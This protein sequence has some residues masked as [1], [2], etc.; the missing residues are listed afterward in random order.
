MAIVKM[1][2]DLPLV[3]SEQQAVEEFAV[4]PSESAPP[5]RTRVDF[6]STVLRQAKKQRCTSRISTSYSTHFS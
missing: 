2:S 6:A 1:Q 5:S 4:E 3:T